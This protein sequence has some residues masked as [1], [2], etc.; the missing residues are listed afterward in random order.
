MSG[1]SEFQ[2]EG[3]KW[4]GEESQ[5]IASHQRGI[6]ELL[7]PGMSWRGVGA[8]CHNRKLVCACVSFIT[9]TELRAF[10]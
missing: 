6:E 2:S 8:F 10:E 9:T 3:K 7:Q 5:L 1:V 4:N